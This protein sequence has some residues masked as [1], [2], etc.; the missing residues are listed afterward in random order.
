MMAVVLVTLILGAWL[1]IWA[2]CSVAART[3]PDRQATLEADRE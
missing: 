2:L 1:C 3:P